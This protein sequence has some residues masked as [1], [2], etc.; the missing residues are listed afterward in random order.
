MQGI[1]ASL[2]LEADLSADLGPA[3]SDGPR[4]EV[5]RRRGTVVGV[6]E[7]NRIVSGGDARLDV[8]EETRASIGAGLHGGKRRRSIG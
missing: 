4:M 3:R 7:P 6:E 8:E 2:D 5:E 1:A